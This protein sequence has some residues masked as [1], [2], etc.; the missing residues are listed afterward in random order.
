[1]LSKGRTGKRKCN[2]GRSCGATCISRDFI[3]RKGL[4]TP[5]S[6]SLG[7][8]RSNIIEVER[9][10]RGG[11]QSL[12]GENLDK[13]KLLNRVDKWIKDRNLT[14][15][16]EVM[17]A[18]TAYQ[19]DATHLLL[20]DYLGKSSEQLARLSSPLTKGISL[21]EEAF[22]TAIEGLL[23]PFSGWTSYNR[24]DKYKPFSYSADREIV[25]K[26][27]SSAEF[28]KAIENAIKADAEDFGLRDSRE[29][30]NRVRISNGIARILRRASER[31][32]FYDFLNTVQYM[33]K[34]FRHSIDSISR[35]SE[36]K[37]GT[38]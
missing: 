14:P 25:S 38:A 22:V 13:N 20:K 3:C 15:P 36:R 12:D 1:M 8:V 35:R 21:T 18:L 32:D 5:V 28:K 9:K 16:G 23:N 34:S 6:G 27:L 31:P 26:F 30:G 17:D 37:Y 2:T 4:P 24:R 10:K 7:K 11:G 29:Y 19:H 33:E